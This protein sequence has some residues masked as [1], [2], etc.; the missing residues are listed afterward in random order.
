V[1]L[2]SPPSKVT[3]GHSLAAAGAIE[4]VVAV[5]TLREQVIT[6]T[7]GTTEIDPE[8]ALDVV[9]GWDPRSAS[10]EHVLSNSFGFGGHNGSLVFKRATA[11]PS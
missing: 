7:A 6:P 3:L 8:I 9:L 4:S 1:S 10:I 11:S 2:P 5:M